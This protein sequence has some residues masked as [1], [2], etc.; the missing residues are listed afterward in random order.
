M[1]RILYLVFLSA[2]LL[3]MAGPVAAKVGP[4]L[5]MEQDLAL[6]ANGSAVNLHTD[7][8]GTAIF[9]VYIYSTADADISFSIDKPIVAT[10]PATGTTTTGSVNVV[11]LNNIDATSGYKHKVP[12]A[13][14]LNRLPNYTLEGLDSGTVVVEILGGN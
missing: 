8:L 14:P 2:V 12:T 6:T 11:D 13:W 7:L 10:D 5:F 9:V 1:R 3:A 4:P